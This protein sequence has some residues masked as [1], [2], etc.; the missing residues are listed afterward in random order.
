[1][2]D[3]PPTHASDAS[4]GKT[5]TTA[6]TAA[7]A[8]AS[9]ERKWLNPLIDAY[10]AVLK[11]A[12]A[13]DHVDVYTKLVHALRSDPAAAAPWQQGAV[14]WVPPTIF[15]TDSVRFDVLTFTCDLS[16]FLVVMH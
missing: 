9:P 10:E 4:N 7:P 16:Y 15:G 14:F 5:A 6:A 1:V 11:E 3:A 8:A 13:M 12:K 2:V